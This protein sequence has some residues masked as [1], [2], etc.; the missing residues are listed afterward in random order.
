MPF[1]KK[2]SYKTGKVKSKIISTTGN[3]YERA[4]LAVEHPKQKSAGR[5]NK[6]G[7]LVPYK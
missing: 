2:A 7:E 6:K 5:A 1:G 4:R 3:I